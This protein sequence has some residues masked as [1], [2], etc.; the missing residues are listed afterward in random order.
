M[1]TLFE[2]F[3]ISILKINKV[4]QKIKLYEMESFGLQAIHVMCIFYIAHSDDGITAGELARQ[5]MEDK[6]AVSRA[7]ALLKRKGYVCSDEHK[8][9]S[10]L[11]LTDEG[12]KVAEFIDDAATRAV[13]A[14]MDDTL[15]DEKR[16]EFYTTLNY[17]YE[18]LKEYYGQLL[19]A[20]K[21]KNGK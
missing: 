12:K 4:V 3:T 9:N 11:Y 16:R 10:R 19:K 14:G 5:S 20:R 2:N 17:I 18:N 1:D 21:E 6:A 7:L 13:N 8:Y 15:T